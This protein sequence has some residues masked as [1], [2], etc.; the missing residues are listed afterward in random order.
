MRHWEEKFLW[1]LILNECYFAW[2]VRTPRL[3]TS[4]LILKVKLFSLLFI[5]VTCHFQVCF[6]LSSLMFVYLPSFCLCSVFLICFSSF[7]HPYL[8]SLAHLYSFS[9]YSLLPVFLDHSLWPVLH[10]L[11]LCVTQTWIWC[12]PTW[13]LSQGFHT[14]LH[15]IQLQ[16]NLRIQCWKFIFVSLHGFLYAYK[17]CV[18][19][20]V[21]FPTWPCIMKQYDC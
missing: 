11:G 15:V 13:E 1:D 21:C 5:L 3:F 10:C 2:K 12:R 9:F 19:F 18:Y 20:H 16:L 17:G 14:C 4:V 7:C 6:C 8:F